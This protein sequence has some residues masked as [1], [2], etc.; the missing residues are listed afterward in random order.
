VINASCD[1]VLVLSVS[2]VIYQVRR[3]ALS[4]GH[5]MFCIWVSLD[6][7]YSVN[8]SQSFNHTDIVHSAPP[9]AAGDSTNNS[10]HVCPS[11]SYLSLVKI[12]NHDESFLR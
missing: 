8:Y 12:F 4:T 7:Q 3:V 1:N 6:P 9:F 2:D 11:L 5:C 10:I